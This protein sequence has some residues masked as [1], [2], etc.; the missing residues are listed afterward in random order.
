M[1]IDLQQALS[2]H[3]GHGGFRKGQEAVV[4]S[5]LSGRPTIAI[6]PTGGGKS[7]CYQLPAMLLEGTT[8]VVS[9]LV[10]LM[11][12]QVDALVARG[13]AATFI[14]SSLPDAE[15]HDRQEALRRGEL[16]LVYVAPERFRSRSFLSALSG[17]HVP[18]IAIDEAHCISA[19]GHDFRPEYQRLAQARQQI[20]AER[21]LALTATATPEVRQDIAEALELENPRVFVAGFDRPNL[22]VEV[23]PVRGDKDKLGRL[24]ALAQSQPPGLVYA[25]TRKN[26]EKIV[27]ALRA[28]GIDALGYHAGM[29]DTERTSVQDRFVR[30]SAPVI[31]ATNAFGMGVD[32]PDIRFVAHFDVPRSLEAYY[33]EIGRAGRDG[34]D[35]LA[36]LLFNYADVMMQR[37]M[38]DSGRPSRELVCTV[39][40]SAR[41]L[42]QGSLDTLAAAAAVHPSEAQSAVRILESAGHLERSRG[43]GGE[44]IALTPSVP[45]ADLAVDFEL[46]ELRV[47]RERKM[48]DRLV[49]FADT[50]GCRRQN[51]LRYFGDVEAPRGCEACESCKGSRAPEPVET[52]SARPPKRRS[53][54]PVA[55]ATGDV[56]LDVFEKLRALRT[57]LARDARVPPYVIFHDATLRELSRTLPESESAFLAVKG[58]GPSRLEKYGARVLAITG[59]AR[60]SRPAA[61]GLAAVPSLS[62]VVPPSSSQAVL[63]LAPQVVPP[64][65]RRTSGDAPVAR[66]RVAPY[67]LSTT[68]AQPPPEPRLP[69]PLPGP[70]R[71]EEK[72]P[73]PASR[74]GRA[75]R[76]IARQL[77]L[78]PRTDG[79]RPRGGEGP[80]AWMDEIPSPSLTAWAAPASALPAE[81]SVAR[82]PVASALWE[83]C[84]SGATLHEIA[85]QVGLPVAEVASQLLEGTSGGRR[86]DVARLLGCERVAAIRAAAGAGDGDLVAVRRRLPFAAALAEIRLALQQ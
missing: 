21:V 63:P 23:L 64:I 35:S 53:V 38:I 81:I 29:D 86:L 1:E 2:K 60:G 12:D 79:G 13:I 51:L 41:S 24:V 68:P 4:R 31:V 19:W 76:P 16:R 69:K 74:A 3:F 85:F 6:L 59:A 18:L 43:R 34:R 8:V 5:V 47:A 46:L 22:F 52:A 11:K 20:N 58:A 15:R 80:P 44:F 17:V 7:L 37:R 10:A 25:A 27:G 33:Q 82:E 56:D 57:E 78:A 26:V 40:E 55:D 67:G 14:N 75:H 77:D 84:T 70:A 54:A 73:R 50:K 49:R 62:E 36:L 42:G 71:P 45:A 48:L 39:W 9:P 72:A 83:L 65:I 32:K 30:G 61:D 66:E 28:N